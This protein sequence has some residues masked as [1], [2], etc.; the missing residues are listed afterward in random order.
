MKRLRNIFD[1]L[2]N[3]TTTYTAMYEGQ[4]KYVDPRFPDAPPFVDYNPTY[5]YMDHIAFEITHTHKLAQNK[6]TV[7]IRIPCEM[8][9]GEISDKS[10]ER[11]AA[12]F[13]LRE[14]GKFI[15]HLNEELYSRSNNDKEKGRYFF[16]EP[17]GE[18]IVRNTAYFEVCA[19]KD[20]RNGG[21]STALLLPPEELPEPKQCLCIK[22]QV[23]FPDKNIHKSKKMICRD[24]PETVSEFIS[25]LNIKGYEAALELSKIQA[26][27][28]QWLK[29]N[30][31]CAFIANG[32]ILPRKKN[33]DLPMNG[34]IPFRSTLEDEIDIF[35]IR[36]MGIK[37]GVTVI[38]GGGYSGKS[39]L[40]DAISAGIYDHV[41]GDGREYCITDETAITITAED[42]RC[43]KNVNIS[44]FI[45]WLPNGDT[46]DFST[47]HASGSTSQGANIMEAIDIGSKLLLIDEDRSATNFMIRDK[48]M[49]QLIV[50]EPITPFT[51]R[52]NEMHEQHN[53]STILVIGGSGE[54][55]SVADNIYMMDEFVIRNV[56]ENAKTIVGVNNT[57]NDC[58]QYADWTQNRYLTSEHFSPYPEKSGTEKLEVSDLGF[59]IIGD[60]KIDVRGLNDIVTPRQLYT[61]GF[62]LRYLE[63]SNNDSLIDIVN[64]VDGLYMRI[65]D[66]GLDFLYSTFFTTCERFLDLPRKSEVYQ[67][68]NRMRKTKYLKV[69]KQR[70]S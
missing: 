9:A 27:I 3:N 70:E 53:I 7:T 16:C 36:G 69:R 35:G 42:G 28:R 57:E 54:Y 45:K 50:K 2:P 43:I 66:E 20:Y 29:N 30:G 41:T 13:Y 31:Y 23:Q 67:V 10:L 17:G 4:L 18:V 38:T 33:S 21:G 8:L 25:G 62:L 49:K 26:E 15:A 44:P 56:T 55:L 63:I 14:F 68:I 32:S 19:Q 22:L 40:L 51:D 11:A 12:D 6:P 5:Y 39:T 37:K 46:A 65:Y 52:V 64:R 60:E 47:D 34:A 48:L 24:L 1:S 59:I 58:Q 61:I